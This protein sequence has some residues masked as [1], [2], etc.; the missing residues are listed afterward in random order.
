[1]NA[2]SCARSSVR[3]GT[4]VPHARSTRPGTRHDINIPCSGMNI[5][6]ED[7]F[8]LFIRIFPLPSGRFQS[9]L[10]S[11][12]FTAHKESTSASAIFK[13]MVSPQII[14]VAPIRSG[15]ASFQ[16]MFPHCSNGSVNCLRH[17]PL[18]VWVRATV[19]RFRKKRGPE[20]LS[21]GLPE[22]KRSSS[23]NLSS[24]TKSQGALP[25]AQS[26]QNQ[27]RQYQRDCPTNSIWF[28]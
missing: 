12:R 10:L 27:Q 20:W 14:G 5:Q 3:R 25:D 9:T 13:K 1:M 24:P 28:P 26:V 21:A 11:F 8:C 23:S 2:C 22:I 18:S 17:S 7:M 16:R 6:G 19:A 15:K 4:V